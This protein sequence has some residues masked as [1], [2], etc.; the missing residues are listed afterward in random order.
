MFPRSVARFLVLTCALGGAALPAHARQVLPGEVERGR[1]EDALRAYHAAVADYRRGRDGALARVESWDRRRVQQVLAAVG[2]AR[3]EARPW[4]S[5]RFK[6]AAMMHTDVALRLLGR[7]EIEAALPH[8]DAAG[9]LLKM[10][11]PDLRSYSSRWHQ[12]VARVLRVRNLLPVAEAFL[13]AAR[14]RQPQD[15]GI[16]YE[17]GV[18]QEALATDTVIPI[19]ITLVNLEPAPSAASAPARRLDRDVVDEM[20]R[21]RAARLNRAAAWLRESLARDSANALA[22]LHLGRVQM[23]REEDD[24]ALKLLNAVSRSDDPVTAYL[25][26]LFAGGLRERQ[27]RLDA[28]AQAYREAIERLPSSHAAYVALSAVLQRTG[29]GDESREVLRRAVDG[30]EHSRREPL[31]SYLV[32]P[33]SIAAERLDPLRQEARQ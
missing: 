22:R 29:R 13:E 2:T 24:D 6:A 5:A 17:S 1:L 7:A 23:L 3:D 31:W 32:E 11:G 4:D 30:V 15:A 19:V 8:V 26:T 14:D 33:A 21:R 10:A 28:A 25:A 16:L 18:L 27:G 9:R 20:K 12:A